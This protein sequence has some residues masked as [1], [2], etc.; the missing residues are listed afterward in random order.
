MKNFV[1]VLLVLFAVAALLRADVYFKILYLLFGVYLLSRLW[2]QRSAAALRVERRFGGR[3]FMGDRVEV[4]LVIENRGT[5]PVPW[6]E[7]NE[8]LP[9]Q[10]MTPPFFRQVLSLAGHEHCV[11]HYTLLCRWRGYY[12]IGPLKLRTG[13]L[14]GL[15]RNTVVE[16]PPTYLIVYPRVVPLQRLGLPTRSPLVALPARSPL[17]EDPSRLMGV[18]AY[19]R[20]DSPRRIHWRATASAGHLL[21]KQYQP[22]IARETLLCLDLNEES[23]ER[24][25]RFTATELAVVVAA[26]LANHILVREGLPVGLLCAASDP[27]LAPD[28]A[29]TLPPRSERAHLM[30]LLERL[31]RVQ[32]TL[33]LSF[34]DLVRRE[35]VHL[36]W[37]ASV[38]LITG[39]VSDALFD[40]VAF[41][42]RGGVAAAVVLVGSAAPAAGSEQRLRLL[43]VALHR[44]WNEK[45]IGAW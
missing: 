43:G 29:A 23:Y 36:A 35:S 33:D 6:L 34:A 30:S 17:F 9:V 41:L 1:P 39:S 37:G 45:E 21:V 32:P 14:L 27:L 3:A 25:E 20:G 19:Q 24:G 12:P 42:R 16:A 13:D 28:S 26:S 15:H 8:L 40:T 22:A 2:M 4:E 10:L 38:V 7:L 18:R 31:A 11:L 44:V 5:L